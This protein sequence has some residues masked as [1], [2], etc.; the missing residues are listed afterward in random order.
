VVPFRWATPALPFA[1]HELPFDV[2][3]EVIALRV[4]TAGGAEVFEEGG[5]VPAQHAAAG[6]V[7]ELFRISRDGGDAPGYEL[8]GYGALDW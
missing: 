7:P 1:G 5:N 8:K 3:A 4:P 6:P 2:G